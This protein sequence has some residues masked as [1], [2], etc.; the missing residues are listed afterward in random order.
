M[1]EQE[2]YK[3]VLDWVKKNNM[4]ESGDTV[5]C[6]VS[7]GVDSVVLLE[8]MVK[9]RKLLNI[10]VV[11]AHF[12][13][14]IRVGES[15]RDQMFVEMLCHKLN[16]PCYVSSGDVLGRARVTGESTEEAA[17]VLRYEFLESIASKFSGKVATAHH[18]DDNLETILISMIHG[19][20]PTG[21]A[22]IPPVRGRII[23]PLLCV[24]RDEIVAHAKSIGLNHVEDSTN[25]SDDYLRNRIRHHI[26][27]LL[28]AEN[29]NIAKGMVKTSSL[30]REDEE[31]IAS[32]KEKVIHEASLGNN[33]YSCNAFK[34]YHKSL[35]GRVIASILY[36]LD[37]DVNTSS[38]ESLLDCIYSSKKSYEVDL[39]N[40]IIAQKSGDV[41]YIGRRREIPGVGYTKIESG[42]KIPIGNTRYFVHC[43]EIDDLINISKVPAVMHISKDSVN[44]DLYI[45]SIREGDK[46]KMPGGTKRLSKVLSEAGY[47][48]YN[49]HTCP[50]I[51]DGSGV[52][53]VYG[54]G[55]DMNHAVNPHDSAYEIRIRLRE[56]DWDGREKL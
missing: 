33:E 25:K 50:V 2:M 43:N 30:L 22:G 9:L 4:I 31:L 1:E 51:A 10:H 55:V 26:T 11:A 24:T 16:I 38:I 54:V 40:N 34:K 12:N 35:L 6:A 14:C 47:T 36:D 44:G 23:R 29:P 17:R 18:A 37:V 7:G 45:R 19:T 5:V 13:H 53:A 49:K 27:P 8:V 46:I 41:I 42:S 15:D 39:N 28:R 48:K 32:N 52:V 56:E 21:L 3:E 20:S